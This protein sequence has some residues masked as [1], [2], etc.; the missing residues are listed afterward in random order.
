MKEYVEISEEYEKI[1]RRLI[2]RRAKLRF[3]KEC[4]IEIGYLVSDRSKTSNGKLVCADC[5]RVPP[6][7]MP[8]VH[9]DF[10]IT[11]YEPNIAGMSEKQLE[12]LIYHELQHVGLRNDG[13]TTYIN[14]HDIEDFEDIIKRYGLRWSEVV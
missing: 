8:Y 13:E 7:Y 5:R 11:V 9:K 10:L 4:G 14:P 3:I 12:I 6:V 2:S 1:G